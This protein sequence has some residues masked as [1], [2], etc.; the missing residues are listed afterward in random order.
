[1]EESEQYGVVFLRKVAKRKSSYPPEHVVER[2]ENANAR[3][4]YYKRTRR[5][6]NN[7]RRNERVSKNG[8]E[9]LCEEV[10]TTS[11]TRVN[12]PMHDQVRTQSPIDSSIESGDLWELLPFSVTANKENQVTLFSSLKRL[13][14]I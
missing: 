10:Q 2:Q 14:G 1:M 6:R 8:P 3:R 12:E 13:L 9:M 7:I 11:V 4:S 5:R